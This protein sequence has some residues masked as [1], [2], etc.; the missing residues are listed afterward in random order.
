MRTG[1]L[2]TLS[3]R[4]KA[5]FPSQFFPEIGLNFVPFGHAPRESFAVE[6]LN[7]TSS[8]LV[9]IGDSRGTVTI[10][11]NENRSDPVLS[12]QPIWV[13]E[14]NTTI[15]VSVNSDRNAGGDVAINYSA[16]GET[17]TAAK[18]DFRFTEGSV[19][20]RQGESE[21]LIP[22]EIPDDGD[23]E[24][25]ETFRLRVESLDG[26][27]ASVEGSRDTIITI[28]DNEE[29]PLEDGVIEVGLLNENLKG[30]IFRNKCEVILSFAPSS[31]VNIF[32]ISPC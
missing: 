13:G 23:V 26:V 18:G 21:V 20:L 3:K 7:V 32:E 17:A 2:V 6:I 4:T 19:T 12:L 25:I 11:D 5:G 9:E 8:S 29:A 22:I 31:H 15:Q 16:V 28:I 10:V 14:Q 24:N 30:W 27:G 1:C